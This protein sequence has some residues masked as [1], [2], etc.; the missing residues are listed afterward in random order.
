LSFEWQTTI[1]EASNQIGICDLS[2]ESIWKEPTKIGATCICWTEHSTGNIA[3]NS[4]SEFVR[5]YEIQ[6]VQMWKG[7]DYTMRDY[8]SVIRWDKKLQSPVTFLRSW[9]FLM[10]QLSTSL[11]KSTAKNCRIWG[12]EKPQE[13]WQHE[14]DSPKLSFW[15]VIRNSRIIGPFFFEEGAENVE[16]YRTMLQDFLIPELQQL[17]LSDRT[18]YF[19]RTVHPTTS[20]PV[21]DSYGITPSQTSRRV[22]LDQL[23]GHFV[24]WW[25]HWTP[26]FEVTLKQER[27]HRYNVLRLKLR[28]GSRMLFM[29]SV[30]SN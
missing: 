17:N 3:Q 11:T 6:E 21:N 27:I 23:L 15:W 8:I 29:K 28:S 22:E 5:T 4:K 16:C 7:G 20:L 25:L 9:R 12:W 30:R 18:F 10:R 13:V 24:D 2:K 26:F 1:R 19:S 14:R